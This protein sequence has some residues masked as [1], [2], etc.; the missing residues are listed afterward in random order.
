MKWL[1]A[2]QVAER[3]GVTLNRVYYVQRQL[4]LREE[5]LPTVEEVINYSPKQKGRPLK[6]IIISEENN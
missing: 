6:H 3:A 2:K 4:G 1:N 5:R